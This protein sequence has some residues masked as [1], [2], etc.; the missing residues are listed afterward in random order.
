VPHPAGSLNPFYWLKRL[1]AEVER[2]TYFD[3]LHRLEYGSMKK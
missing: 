2:P 1:I 3:L